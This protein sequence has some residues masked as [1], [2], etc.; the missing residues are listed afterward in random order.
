MECL[1]HP[2]Q[3]ENPLPSP[4]ATIPME[5]SFHPNPTP[6]THHIPQADDPPFESIGSR[7]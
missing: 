2:H 1:S 6:P 7:A 4:G 5:R 3:S